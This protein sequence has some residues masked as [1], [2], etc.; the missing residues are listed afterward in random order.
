[1]SL[2]KPDFSSLG[3]FFS[4]PPLI[5]FDLG[6]EKLNMVQV[7]YISGKPIITC[8]TSDY[9]NSSYSALLEQPE[10]LQKLVKSTFKNNAFKGR[11]VVASVPQSIIKIIFLNF[12]CK[13]HDVE[14]QALLNALENRTRDNL[15]DY[16]I[17]YVSINPYSTEQVNRTALVAMAKYDAVENYLDLLASCG[18]TVDALEI[19][20]IAIK[21]LISAITAPDN[22]Q[23][24][25]VI[26]FGAKK[27]YLTVIWH[28][29]LLLDR[30][31]DFGMDNILQTIAKAFDTNIQTALDIL[32]RYG[33]TEHM[34]EPVFD[35]DERSIQKVLIDILNSSFLSL[36]DEIKD[37]LIYVASETRGGAVEFIYLMGSLTRFS[38]V[39][40]IIDRLISIPVKTINPFYGFQ[41]NNKPDSFDDLGPLSGVAVATGLSL[42][43]NKNES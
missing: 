15:T 21:R 13:V 40:Q 25:L 43:G 7:S 4:S 19:G 20:P 32:H 42:R 16:V 10:L 27:S 31:I 36:A 24:I 18:L 22:D 38:S 23:K 3:G 29:E 14:S 17:D 8:A 30:E 1:M 9:H 34:A 28:N 26:N 2:T 12:Q 37:V 11:K 41:L 6:L 5:G 33:L 39:D 35:E